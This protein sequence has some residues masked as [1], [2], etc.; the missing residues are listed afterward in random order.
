MTVRALVTSTGAVRLAVS[1]MREAGSAVARNR[2]RRRVSAAL[3]AEL[4]GIPGAPSA[5]L[6]VSARAA[7][8][9]A[10][11]AELR[12]AARQALDTA[13]GARP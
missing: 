6:L 10:P 12:A 3:R 5:D 2:A 1:G 13:L 9:R 4:A 11:F 8:A 7:A